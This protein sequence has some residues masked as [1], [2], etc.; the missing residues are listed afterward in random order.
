[1]D[2]VLLSHAH[3]DHMDLPTLARFPANTL[4]VTAKQTLDLLAG[5]PLKAAT[6]LGW[7]DRVRLKTAAG[8]LEIEALQ[9]RHWGRRWPSDLDRG[10]NGYVLRREGKR[11]LFAGDTAMTDLFAGHR[12][13][14]PFEVGIMPIAAYNPWIRNHC[15]P[16]E[17]VQMAEA[18]G[19]RHVLPVHHE[20]FQLSDEPMTEPI[21]RFTAA[22]AKEPERIALKQA[23]ETFVCPVA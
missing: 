12:A 2:V 14:G 7:N 3:F 15:T 22:L 23:G 16:E 4:A 5:T 13:K 20:T 19:A 18:A 17:A 10:Y 21:E 8:D 6:E 9:V 11:L 1:V